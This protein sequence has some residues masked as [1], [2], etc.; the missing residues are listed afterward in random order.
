MY[1]ALFIRELWIACIIALAND[2]CS[3]S[4]R[5]VTR[6]II[7]YDATI[8]NCPTSDNGESLI[9]NY[10]QFDILRSHSFAAVFSF[11]SYG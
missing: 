6:T 1:V 5:R 10:L 8:R 7:T 2:S 9:N 4:C 3:S 11:H